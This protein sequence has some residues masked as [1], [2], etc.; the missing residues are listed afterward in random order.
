MPFS[1]SFPDDPHTKVISPDPGPARGLVFFSVAVASPSWRTFS[2]F[3]AH[4]FDVGQRL[5]KRLTRNSPDCLT[6]IPGVEFVNGDARTKR[7]RLKQG[8]RACKR[9]P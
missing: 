9:K 1:V 4:E 5:D 2:R 8:R 3:F 6:L 7:M